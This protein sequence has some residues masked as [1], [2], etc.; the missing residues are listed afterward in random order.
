MEISKWKNEVQ[1]KRE[2]KDMFFSEHFQSPI[3]PEERLE[4]EGLDYHP[5]N[6]KYRFEIELREHTT[7][8]KIKMQDTQGNEREFLRWGEFEFRIDNKDCKLQA[9]K[10]S[11]E[12]EWLFIPFRDATSGKETYGAGRYFDLDPNQHKTGEEKWTIDFNKAYDPRCAYSEFYAC[13]FVPI[14]NWLN[15]PI[16]A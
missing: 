13:P 11:P 8:E 5:P 16:Y 1:I 6:L 9:Y 14:E 15:V 7:K 3:L 10:S 12:E 4:F 2:K